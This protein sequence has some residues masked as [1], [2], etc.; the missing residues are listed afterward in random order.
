M[1]DLFSFQKYP[2]RQNR[3]FFLREIWDPWN[4]H[5]LA[6]LAGLEDRYPEHRSFFN[7]LP[8]FWQKMVSHSWKESSFPDLKVANFS[9]WNC[10]TLECFFKSARTLGRHLVAAPE[11][12]TKTS[13]RNIWFTGVVATH[14]FFISHSKNWGIDARQLDQLPTSASF[15]WAKYAKIWYRTSAQWTPCNQPGVVFFLAISVQVLMG[16]QIWGNKKHLGFR[17]AQTFSKLRRY[18]FPH[19]PFMYWFGARWFGARW[20]G[21]R[22]DPRMWK[23]LLVKGTPLVS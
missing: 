14:I 1:S 7:N 20:F 4:P 13:H 11:F 17:M 18:L 3:V 16:Q 8:N 12:P 21:F 10:E 6:R 23:G 5:N 19:Q 22:L 15:L 2:F 9:G